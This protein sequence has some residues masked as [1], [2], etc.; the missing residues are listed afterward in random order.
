MTI[1]ASEPIPPVSEDTNTFLRSFGKAL[2]I[3]FLPHLFAF[4]LQSSHLLRLYIA[5]LV[6]PNPDSHE[7]EKTP[8]SVKPWTFGRKWRI[9]SA[10]V[11]LS[12]LSIVQF[13]S[14]VFQN[15]SP[16]S[17]AEAV[18]KF[19]NYILFIVSF[20]SVASITGQISHP[21]KYS[22]HRNPNGSSVCI[23]Q[24]GL[25]L[26]GTRQQLLLALLLGF[27][28]VIFAF[29]MVGG[30]FGPNHTLP[31][32]VVTMAYI[33]SILTVVARW[34]L[35]PP[36]IV[37]SVI[38]TAAA[39]FALLLSNFAATS[40]TSPSSFVSEPVWDSGSSVIRSLGSFSFLQAA[41]SSLA[42]G[43]VIA[44]ALR[45]DFRNTLINGPGPDIS[46]EV[47][48][49][50]TD[51]KITK[52]IVIPQS[53]PCKFPKP[54]YTL[55]LITWS[56][57]RIA[58]LVSC[59]VAGFPTKSIYDT[60]QLAFL[61]EFPIMIIALFILATIR[62]ESKA[63]WNYK[64]VWTI[65]M[66]A[67]PS[68]STLEEGVPLLA[69]KD[70]VLNTIPI[71]LAYIYIA[72]LVAQ[73]PNPLELPEFSTVNI[74]SSTSVSKWRIV[75]AVLVL[76]MFLIS[77][78]Q[79]NIELYLPLQLEA[80]SW[81]IHT[82]SEYAI[83]A[84]LF[85][86]VTLITAQ[87]SYPGKVIVHRTSNGHYLTSTQKC[88]APLEGFLIAL[89]ACSIIIFALVM[90]TGLSGSS[91]LFP[92]SV[93]TM[94][95]VST[96]QLVGRIPLRPLTIIYTLFMFIIHALLL[97]IKYIDP[98]V[99]QLEEDSLW[100]TNVFKSLG[101]VSFLPATLGSLF[102]GPLIA[103]MLRFDFST[104]I[105]RPSSPP[106]YFES[107]IPTPSYQSVGCMPPG[108]VVSQ[109]LLPKASFPKPY[110]ILAATTWALIRITTLFLCLAFEFPLKSPY[111]ACAFGIFWEFPI[112]VMMLLLFGMMRGEAKALW[113]YKEKWTIEPRS[114]SIGEGD[115]QLP[116]NDNT[117]NLNVLV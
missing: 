17:F 106:I 10:I 105:N 73:T 37:Y 94:T 66:K 95:Y 56:L 15:L 24:S 60:S 112:L 82:I 21:H 74:Q 65:D 78:L 109:S 1:I 32:A 13:Y 19:N 90:V 108:I 4:I 96:I 115:K 20:F 41:A 91:N 23:S 46:Y 83:Y 47:A 42:G 26:Q 44:C 113:S 29:L 99:F 68:A 38:I 104:Y 70:E 49:H 3:F 33:S 5:L 53:L 16:E 114:T 62:G 76:S 18:I 51:P 89:L 11:V 77:I 2:A 31:I 79:W 103:S 9:I 14:T 116:T 85:L 80:L 101:Y 102:T 67:K 25:G 22:V 64:E 55:A 45:F 58:I 61:V 93:V 43:V 36:I 71:V 50:P 107:A 12:I 84:S 8:D 34:P 7:P 28:V 100:K 63:L 54:Y 40:D 117:I 35:R 97:S 57:T 98:S 88:F 6:A 111:D 69:N 75:S 92:I 86:S 110:Y 81:A 30:L 27:I 39:I 72:L 87:V 52:G 59:L 48:L